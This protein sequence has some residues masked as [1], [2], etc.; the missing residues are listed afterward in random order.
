MFSLKT[1]ASAALVGAFAVTSAIAGGQNATLKVDAKKSSLK[2]FA[3]KV[4]GKHDG[5]LKIASGTIT[6]DGKKVIGGNFDIDMTSITVRDVQDAATNA[7]LV[8]HLKSADFFSADAFKTA[9]FEIMKVVPKSGNEYI[10]AG[11][12]TIKGISQEVDFP[13]TII[14]TGNSVNATGKITLDRTKWD[15]RYGS[16]KF[17][18]NIGDKAIHDDF[19]IDFSLVTGS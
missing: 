6:T 18:E 4:T 14:T 8:G 17:F 16:G 11:K 7:K 5:Q 1:I 19:V 9:N 12:M 2:W 15:I 3:S 10:V 13:A